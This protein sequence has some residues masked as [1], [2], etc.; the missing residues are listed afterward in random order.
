MVLGGGNSLDSKM[1][2]QL[3]WS[4]ILKGDIAVPEYDPILVEED[5]KMEKEIK[6]FEDYNFRRLVD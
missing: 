2:Y 3:P 5:K 4:P 1:G 6:E